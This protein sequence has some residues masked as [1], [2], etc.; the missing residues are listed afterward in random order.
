LFCAA[1]RFRGVSLAR[2]HARRG[3]IP[4]LT[5]SVSSRPS[6]P[7]DAWATD[8]QYK[9]YPFFAFYRYDVLWRASNVRWASR[10]D[11]YLSMDNA[12]PDKV[13]V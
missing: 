12:V 9:M 10:W 13:S 5:E 3:R 11:I 1:A 6:S 8:T 7:R 2:R 4:S